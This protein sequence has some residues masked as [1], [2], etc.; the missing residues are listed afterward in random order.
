MTNIDFT[1]LVIVGALASLVVEF[2]KRVSGANKEKSI[3]LS[4]L[5]SL[6]FATIYHFLRETSYWQ[7]LLTIL[8]IANTV[9][10]FFRGLL[11]K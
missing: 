7:S 4:I 3:A 9:Y 1:S 5:V 8:G 11:S 10:G 2:I 6:A